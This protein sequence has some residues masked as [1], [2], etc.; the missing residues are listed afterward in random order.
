[1]K[2]DPN[3]SA[4]YRIHIY[5]L[6]DETWTNRLSGL[7]ISHRGHGEGDDVTILEGEVLDQAALFGVLKTIYDLR[8][9]LM[10]VELLGRESELFVRS[11]LS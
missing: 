10:S 8:M 3:S 4:T 7:S 5:G 2:I 9:P 6:L 11:K 1:M